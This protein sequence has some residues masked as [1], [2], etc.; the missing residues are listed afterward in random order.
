MVKK[1]S[2]KIT[3]FGSHGEIGSHLVKNFYD[4]YEIIAISKKVQK[5]GKIHSIILSNFIENLVLQTLP[6]LLIFVMRF[7]PI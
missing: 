7:P 6:R 2:E 3:I 4:L 1:T 5:Y